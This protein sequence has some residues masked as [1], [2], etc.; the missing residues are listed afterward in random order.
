MKIGI[1]TTFS[2]F[3]SEFSLTT[4]VKQQL[5]MLLKYDYKPVLYV[6][7]IFKD[8]DKVPKGVEVKAILPQIML[9][10]Y[11]QKKLD[12]LDKDVAKI[13]PAM[14]KHMAEALEWLRDKKRQRM[15]AQ[16]SA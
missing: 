11:S 4:V 6:L 10:P 15:R 5:E 2:N 3:N 8:H 7:D 12:T 13:V 16:Q 9:E 1:L 14:E